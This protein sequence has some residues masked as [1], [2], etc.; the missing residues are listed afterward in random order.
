MA[1]CRARAS[2]AA[3]SRIVGATMGGNTE[4][5]KRSITLASTIA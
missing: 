1:G 3:S 5:M 4:G 2:A